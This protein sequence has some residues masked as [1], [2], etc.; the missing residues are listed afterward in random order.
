MVKMGFR[1]NI[2]PLKVLGEAEVEAIHEGAL[3]VLSRTGIA[4]SEERALRLLEDGGCLV[5][6]GEG[7]V[8]FPRT[9]STSALTSAR[10]PSRTGRETQRRVWR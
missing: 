10:Q 6:R 8:R 5:D 3:K 7:R 1:R 4:M 2:A 9:W